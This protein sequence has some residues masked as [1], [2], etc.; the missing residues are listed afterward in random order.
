MFARNLINFC[1]SLV[2]TLI[3]SFAVQAHEYKAGNI[4]IDHP[5]ARSTVPGQGSGGAYLAI[6][7]EG[8]IKDELVKAESTITQSVELHTMEMKN[9]VM[10][11]REVDDIGID[12]GKT[13][14]M[15]PGHGYHL[16][17]IGLKQQL[18]VGDKFPLTLYFKKAGKIDV[19][20]NVEATVASDHQH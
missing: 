10:K 6:K 14:K 4:Q 1:T 9:G 12:A 17:L 7:N 2:C 19:V 5:F 16:M 11:M 3:F 15:Q 18:K 13:I 8:K 20:V